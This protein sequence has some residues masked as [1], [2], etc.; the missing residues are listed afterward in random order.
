MVQSAS[1]HPKHEQ[2][3]DG[4]PCEKASIES[5]NHEAKGSGLSFVTDVKGLLQ[6]TEVDVYSTECPEPVLVLCD[7]NCS[8]FWISETLAEKLKLQ[9]PPTTLTVRGINSQQTIHTQMVE[10]KL[11]PVHSGD[12]RATF[13]IK[14][15]VRTLAPISS[16][17]LNLNSSIHTSSHLHS[18]STA[19]WM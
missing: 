10:L 8:H 7:S 4:E 1:C 11:I 12:S 17:S 3:K 19:T 6:I 14:L 2:S 15:Y 9:G 16:T 13:S 5:R 18:V